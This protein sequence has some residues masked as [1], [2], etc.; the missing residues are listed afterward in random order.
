MTETFVADTEPMQIDGELA[1]RVQEALGENVYL[2][3]QCAKCTSGCPVGE[4]FDWQPNQIMRAVQL[5]QEDIALHSDTPWLCAS[6]Q[7]CTTRCPQGL[8][9]ARIMDF[10]TREARAR[11]IAARVPE[12]QTF[13]EAFLRE[14]RLWNRSYEPGL[15]AEMKL[16][17]PEHLFDDLDLYTRMIRKRKVSLLPEPVRPPKRLKPS[18]KALDGVAYYPGCSLHSTAPEFDISTRAVCEAV[19]LHLEEPDHWVCCGASAAHRADPDEALRLPMI[20]LTQIEQLGFSEVTMPCAACFNRHKAA[21]YEIRH[22]PSARQ[23]VD[24][25][26]GY[27]YRDRVQVNTLID[28]LLQHV[29]LE[30]IEARVTRPLSG[31]RVVCYYGCLLT[32]PPD[33]TEAPHPENPTN[34]DGLVSALGAEVL[35]WSHKTTCC[36]ASH[37]L[38]RP[39]IVLKL[40]GNLLDHAREAGAEAIAVACPLCHTNLDARQFQMDLDVPMPVLYF[41]QLMA[42][43]FGLPPKAASFDRNLVDPRPTLMRHG[44]VEGTSHKEPAGRGQDEMDEPEGEEPATPRIHPRGPPAAFTEPGPIPAIYEDIFDSLDQAWKLISQRFDVVADRP[45]FL[46]VFEGADLSHPRAA[47]GTVVANMLTEVAQ[48]VDRFSPWYTRPAKTYGLVSNRELETGA[49]RWVLSDEG[50]SDWGDVVARLT[51]AIRKDKGLVLASLFLEGNG[52]ARDEPG[53]LVRV[54]CGCTPPR[55]LL[56]PAALVAHEKIVCEACGEI[57]TRLDDG[58]GALPRVL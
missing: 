55:L 39:D 28:T 26:L 45:A 1:R 50:L 13:N 25:K 21:Q 44:L 31:L 37:S 9:I 32:R 58:D 36:G 2:C 56:V 52:G 10:L 3:Y 6:C 14:I 8:D 29:G 38:T 16:R 24:E 51:D 57:F 15:M 19:G 4:F 46:V 7:T 22:D 20:N 33:W 53:V 5:G 23:A 34:M 43:A 11:G 49:L 12:V 35:D 42:A 30:Q 47:A 27:E 40:S 18:S 54:R 48:R 17:M 41:T